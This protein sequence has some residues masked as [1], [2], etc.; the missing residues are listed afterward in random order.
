M[1]R[2]HALVARARRGVARHRRTRRTANRS[3]TPIRDRPA[4]IRGADRDWRA[5][6]IVRADLAAG[7]AGAVAA[8]F[9]TGAI[10]AGL[11]VRNV[12][13][14]ADVLGGT[15]SSLAGLGRALTA[16]DFLATVVVDGAALALTRGFLAVWRAAPGTGTDLTVCAASSIAAEVRARAIWPGLPVDNRG[17]V[18]GVLPVA[19]SSLARLFGAGAAVDFLPAVVQD[20]AALASAGLLLAHWRTADS[21]R[22]NL[23]AG[24]ADALAALPRR[25]AFRARPTVRLLGIDTLIIGACGAIARYF[26]ARRAIDCS[27]A[28]IG[29]RPAGVRWAGR[30]WL[31]AFVLEAD[32][33]SFAALAVAALPR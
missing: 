22:A 11:S 28:P 8:D 32:L 6:T 20:R 29:D 10:R 24:A 7:A 4:G 3:T 5:A 1:R 31:A 27:A 25:R 33:S 18:T 2:V 13:V 21:A 9:R 30:N 17:V 12:R 16:I 19:S 23:T 26:R 14:L 15:G